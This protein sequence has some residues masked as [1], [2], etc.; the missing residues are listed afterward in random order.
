MTLLGFKTILHKKCR[1]GKNS[2]G[3]AENSWVLDLCPAK[4]KQISKSLI[5]YYILI[6]Q[7]KISMQCNGKTQQHML[8][9]T[10]R[11]P[12]KTVHNLK[13]YRVRV[14]VFNATFNNISVIS[15]L[16][17]LL[18]GE[19]EENH[20]PATS[21]GYTLSHNAVSSAPRLSEIRTHNVSDDRHWLHR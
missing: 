13:T 15:W 12:L 2:E 21:H 7:H 16:W 14:M 11:S 4:W 8:Y 1:S 20:R 19:T 6:K 10:I 3:P 17:V 9:N 18:V 5:Q